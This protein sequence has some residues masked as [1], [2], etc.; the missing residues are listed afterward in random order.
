MGVM[1]YHVLRLAQAS[2]RVSMTAKGTMEEHLILETP[3]QVEVSFELAGLASRAVA[4]VIDSLLQILIIGLTLLGLGLLGLLNREEMGAGFDALEGNQPGSFPAM[5]MILAIIGLVFFVTFWGYHVFFELVTGGRT[6]GKQLMRLRVLRDSGTAVTFSD[7]FIRNLV[8]VI[9]FLP[10][11][12]GVG[13][14]AVLFTDRGKRL[15]DL[16]AG[17]VVIRERRLAA[18]VAPHAVVP[19]GPLRLDPGLEQL[20][21]SFLERREG[22]EPHR[23]SE[24]AKQLAHP[25]QARYGGLEL[26]SEPFLEALLYA[27]INGARPAWLSLPDTASNPGLGWADD[28]RS[29]SSHSSEE[30]TP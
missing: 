22:L 9:D 26:A 1:L 13:L 4:C 29:G 21:A 12:Y 24:L 20:I 11:Y 19:G 28:A 25:L 23:R 3:E 15:G 27:H 30:T 7:S 18:S 5:P 16:A 6:P 2:A 10:V 8:R 17:T 14:L